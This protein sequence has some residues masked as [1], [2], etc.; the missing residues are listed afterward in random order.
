MM[1]IDKVGLL[2]L[3]RAWLQEDAGRG[4]L[5]TALVVPRGS[6]A[7]AR[8]EAR[9]SGVVAGLEVAAACFEAAG[10]DGVKW[11]AEASDGDEVSAGTALAR[12]DGDLSA[13]LLAERVALNILGRLSG[14]A[15]LTRRYVDAT[16][17]SKT[18]IVDTRKTTPALR[19]LEK[20]AVAVGGG[21]NHRF[22]LD[23]GI[24]VKDNHI[25]AAGGIGP[26]TRRAVEG[27]PHGL[28]VE[29]EVQTLE[30]M[31]EAIEAG[32]D[33][34]LLDNMSPAEVARAVKDA[35][36]RVVLEASGG[37][38]LQNVGEYARTGVDLIS[39]GA[40]T[41]SATSLDV[42]LEVED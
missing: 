41:H 37:I 22:G 39:I 23:D 28:K 4:D 5:T 18:K 36:G 1:R 32:A 7:R 38:T 3:A 30:Q 9:A 40:L 26:A 15:T 20:H 10:G 2:S 29:V 17:G 34:V 24:L 16:A 33:V 8:L 42:A 14:I 25:A 6:S 21:T 19:A 31:E 12:V 13:I 27:A 11:I 35:A